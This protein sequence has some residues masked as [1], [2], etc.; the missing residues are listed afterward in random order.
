MIVDIVDYSRYFSSVWTH[1]QVSLICMIEGCHATV[2]THESLYHCITQLVILGIVFQTHC[3][4]NN[5]LNLNLAFN[6]LLIKK[7]WIGYT[8][9][10]GKYQNCLVYAKVINLIKTE[11][12]F[13]SRHSISGII[14]AWIIAWMWTGWPETSKA[15]TREQRGR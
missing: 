3:K 9:S 14:P 1:G 4:L 2:N 6:I 5:E 7:N 10:V 15:D 13:L 11:W 8:L 12:Y